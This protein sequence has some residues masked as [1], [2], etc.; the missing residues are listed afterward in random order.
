MK[1]TEARIAAEVSAGGSTAGK[2]PAA[3]WRRETGL[4]GGVIGITLA[5]NTLADCLFSTKPVGPERRLT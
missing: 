2:I 4:Q 5:N 3:H 1:K